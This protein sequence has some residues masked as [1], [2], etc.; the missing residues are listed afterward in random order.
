MPECV[1]ERETSP[2]RCFFGG[3][4]GV[5]VGVWMVKAFEVTDAKL[6]L[7]NKVNWTHISN[8]KQVE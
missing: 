3:G 5:G 4:R 7:I 2:A 6:K 1:C 8:V